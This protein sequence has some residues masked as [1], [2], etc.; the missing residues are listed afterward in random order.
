MIRETQH[1]FPSRP[2]SGEN[3]YTF[4]VTFCVFVY[5]LLKVLEDG[6]RLVL[7]SVPSF[8]YPV[9]H[10][11]LLHPGLTHCTQIKSLSLN[12]IEELLQQQELSSP[13]YC[14]SF[15]LF[16]VTCS[17]LTFTHYL[18]TYPSL[19]NHLPPHFPT[20]PLSYIYTN[21]PSH[22]PIFL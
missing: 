18:P 20:C 5:K 17:R 9:V 21:F 6:W 16:T 11:A 7:M 19:S 10:H 8:L 3:F 1:V 13:L 14:R 22:L 12:H 4:S 15:S 2:T